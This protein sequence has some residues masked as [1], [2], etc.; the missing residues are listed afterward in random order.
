MIS[1]IISYL[2]KLGPPSFDSPI[3]K[4]VYQSLVDEAYYS[5]MT[6]IISGVAVGILTYFILL[7][8]DHNVW[9][10]VWIATYLVFYGIRF[11]FRYLYLKATYLTLQIK[12]KRFSPIQIMI[13][14]S[15]SGLLWLFLF[16][17]VVKGYPFQSKVITFLAIFL[18]SSATYLRYSL[19][20]LWTLTFSVVVGA[21]LCIWL[22]FQG[23]AQALVSL[24]ILIYCFLYYS[25]SLFLF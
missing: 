3:E 24:G 12:E 13:W 14:A 7:L 11:L 10:H 8:Y 9:L 4:E 20:P 15:L 6:P 5:K 22:M 21:P 25:Y 17:I 23:E 19:I 1:K 18:F 2:K 16:F